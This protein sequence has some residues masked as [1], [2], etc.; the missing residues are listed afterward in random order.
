MKEAVSI[1][2]SMPP[3]PAESDAAMQPSAAPPLFPLVAQSATSKLAAGA[4]VSVND[5]EAADRRF[6][7]CIPPPVYSLSTL[8][9]PRYPDPTQ[10]SPPARWLVRGRRLIPR[11]VAI[12]GFRW[13]QRSPPFSCTRLSWRTLS[14]TLPIRMPWGFGASIGVPSGICPRSRTA[15]RCEGAHRSRRGTQTHEGA[16]G[17]R[18]IGMEPRAATRVCSCKARPTARSGSQVRTSGTGSTHSCSRTRLTR[19]PLRRRQPSSGVA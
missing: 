9:S 4:T 18:M 16:D 19:P 1:S 7:G 8:R 5:P 2:V 3:G 10:E 12:A 15:M 6:H 11:G 13:L 14:P 17:R